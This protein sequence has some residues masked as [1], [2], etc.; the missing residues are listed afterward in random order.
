MVEPKLRKE[1]DVLLQCPCKQ[2][3]EILQQLLFG[4]GRWQNEIKA[5]GLQIKDW[6]LITDTSQIDP[7]PYSIRVGI[8]KRVAVGLV[9]TPHVPGEDLLVN[10]VTN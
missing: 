2:N 8:V 7:V 4:A 6:F 5:D 3:A 9:I 1:R 10:V